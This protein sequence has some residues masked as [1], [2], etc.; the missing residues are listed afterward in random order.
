M[1]RRACGDLGVTRRGFLAGSAALG[2][3]ACGGGPAPVTYD[4]TAV[5][6]GLR[7]SGGGSTIIVAEP[8][9]IFAL[10]SERIVVRS[11]GGEIT[12]LPRAQWSDRLPRLVQARLIQSFENAGRAA[13]GRPTDRL[14]GTSQLIVDIRSFEVREANRDAFV[15]VAAK[16]VASGSG[17]IANARLFGASAPVG[18]IDG[19]GA[20]QAL[21]QAL[22]SV[23]TQIVG[24]T[25]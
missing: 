17:R 1:G 13:V 2:V 16:L 6:A 8:S 24:W 9:T 11:A 5:R 14:A 15:E 18:A 22:A 12:Y 4:L 10:D 3:S 7:R 19:A 20:T 25:G 23:I 21:D